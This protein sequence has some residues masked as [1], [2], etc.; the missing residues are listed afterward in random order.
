MLC[1]PST[2]DPQWTLTGTIQTPDHAD[3]PP[4]PTLRLAGRYTTQPDDMSSINTRSDEPKSRPPPARVTA[5]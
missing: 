5:A 2:H 4:S 3:P 1:G